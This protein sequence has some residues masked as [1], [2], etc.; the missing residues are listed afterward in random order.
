M[1]ITV[2]QFIERLS[3]S[4]LMSAAEVSKVQDGLPPHKRPKDVQQLAQVLVQQG[5]L[6]KFQATAVYQGKTKG[7]VFGQYVVLDKLGEG[8]MGVVLKA[9]HRRMKRTV[10]IKIL[11]S[12]AIKQAGA[13]ERFHREVQAAATLS[14]PNI[15]TAYDADEHQGIHYLA[16]EYVEGRDLASIV[17][18]R[19]PLPLR[20][21]AECILQAARGLQYAHGKGIVHRDIKP[22]NLLLDKDGMVKILDMGLARMT[23]PDAALGGPERLTTTGQV[24]GTCDYMAPEQA[25]DSHNVDLRADIYS[26][27]CTLYRLLTGSPPYARES[28][29]QILVAHREDPIPSLRQARPEVPSALDAVFQ[30]M[31]A[32]QPEDRQQ[33]MA[34]VIAELEAILGVSTGRPAVRAPEEP[35]SAAFA[36]SLAFLQ[37]KTPSGTL[38]K[39]KKPTATEHTQPSIGPEHDTGSNILGKAL[40]TVAKLGPKPLV[41][42]GLA[43][44]LVLLLVVVLAIALRHGRPESKIRDLKSEIPPPALAPFDAQKAKEH[45]EAW[46]SYL[47]VPVEMTNSI[48]MEL[49]L[50]PPGEFTMGEGGEAHKVTITSAFY[51]GKYEV[52]QEEWEAVMGKGNNPSQFKGPKN[53]VEQVDWEDCQV[54]L[55]KLTENG[56]AARGTYRLPTEA[57]WEYACRA[58]STGGWSFGDRDL[59]LDD[60]GWY[61]NDSQDTTHPVGQKKPNAWRLY[62]MHGNVWEWCADWFD[63]NYYQASPPSDPTGPP[64]GS[65]RVI[66]GGS[67]RYDAGLCRSA[68]RDIGGPGDRN[69]DLGLRVSLTLAEKSGQEAAPPVAPAE[70][71]VPDLKSE[72]PDLKSE[73]PPPAAGPRGN[74]INL[75]PLVDL[76]QDAVYGNWKATPEGIAVDQPSGASAL[77]LPYEPPEEYDFEIEFSTPGGGLNVN[78]YVFAAGRGFAWKLNSHGVSPPLYG[79]ELLDGKYAKDFAEAAVRK[80]KALEPG[81]RYTSTVEVRR[82]SLRSL[83][84]GE[85]YVKWSGDFSRFSMENITK[86][87]DDRRLGIG[88]YRRAVVFHRAEVREISGKGNLTRAALPR[89]GMGDFSNRMAPPPAIAP[90]DAQKAKG[91]QEAWAKYLGVPV[92]F[93]SSF[94]MK[95]VLVP[96]GEFMMGSDDSE[97][98]TIGNFASE[99]PIHK[100]RISKPFYI[101][102]YIVTV[103]QFRR[104]V[105]ATGHRTEAEILGKGWTVKGIEWDARSGVNW[106]DPGFKQDE[107]HPAV[108]VSWDDAREFCKWATGLAGRT[109][110]LPTEAEWEYAARGPMN[111]KYPWGNQWDGTLANHADQTLKSTG[112]HLWCEELGWSP[113]NDG[114]AYTSPVGAYRNAS[115]CGAFDM[116]GNIWEWCQDWAS[117]TYYAQSPPIDPSGP[118]SGPQHILRGGPWNDPGASLRSTCR[119][120]AVHPYYLAANTGFRAIMEVPDVTKDWPTHASEST[121]RKSAGGAQA[122]DTVRSYGPIAPP[123]AIAPFDAQKAKEHQDAWAKYLSTPVEITNSIGMKLVLIPPG[124]FDMGATPEEIARALEEGKKNQE[125]PAYLDRLPGEGPRHRVRISRPFCLGEYPVSQKEY[126]IVMGWN[127]SAYAATG[128]KKDAVHGGDTSRFPVETVSWEDAVEFCSQLSALPE[129]AAA[130]RTYRLP[131]EAEWEY[132]C[133]A[134]SATRWYC[135]DDEAALQGAAWYGKNAGGVPH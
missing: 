104:F 111:L 126:S 118:T 39:Q 127:P 30:K 58:G 116:A 52:T 14:H 17:K 63:G 16:M 42:V 34:E 85:E 120:R 29:M 83:V 110:R 43:W 97:R 53:P 15:V 98:L 12:A 55:K 76:Q 68:Y 91:P 28:L 81:N 133:R 70:S 115:W 2:E 18:D 22:G 74:V 69:H 54:F 66:R 78:Q 60:Y 77:Q 13:V 64:S 109:V 62:D 36:Q 31:L 113:A 44:G 35:S 86:L 10:A 26:L 51:L 73:I 96:P 40:G 106:R 131:T 24:M 132:A 135:G 105:E 41:L 112:F 4:G 47:G 134:G 23:G 114:Y 93:I 80:P 6:T 65:N 27:G 32:K 100:V 119:L 1:S 20:E 107:S 19:G 57:Q 123:P 5:K 122:P 59:E 72:I 3:E 67:W 11:S 128:T 75:L 46:A 48:G 50:I 129:E 21:A 56:D 9:Q 61:T 8:G 25:F 88:S 49:V 103:A 101:G 89:P 102:K 117:D 87:K 45:Q 124:E 125:G 84:D 108:V 130:R 71:K 7:L 121:D 37:E 94:G 99:K 79:F 33:S 82:G 95:F 92:E 90:F 38:T